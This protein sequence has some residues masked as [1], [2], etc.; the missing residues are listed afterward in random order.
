[1][2]QSG[3]VMFVSFSEGVKAGGL[4]RECKPSMQ[5]GSNHSSRGVRLGFPH[6]TLKT[7]KLVVPV[8]GTVETVECFSS[9]SVKKY[10]SLS[11]TLG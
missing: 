11:G 5:Q 9:L 3:H 1:M 8:L 2:Q 6:A 4:K 10:L 7:V